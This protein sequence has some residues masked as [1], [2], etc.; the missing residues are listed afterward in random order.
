V[1]EQKWDW[2]IKQSLDGGYKPKGI[3]HSD[4]T[5]NFMLW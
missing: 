3:V 2:V 1:H 5:V 4:K